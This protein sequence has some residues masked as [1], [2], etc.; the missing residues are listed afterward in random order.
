MKMKSKQFWRNK[1]K[2]I[3]SAFALIFTIVTM[4]GCTEPVPPGTIGKIITVNGITPEVYEPG[5]PTVWGRDR[6]ILIETASELRP[7]PVS[8]IMA[9]RRIDEQGNST[10]EAGLKM[11]FLVNIR[12]R[13]KTNPSDINAVLSDMSL[14]GVDRITAKQVYTKYGDMVIGRVSREVLGNYTPE[15]VLGNLEKINATLDKEVKESLK[16]SPLVI[17][18][19]SLGP[20]SLP[21]VIQERINKNKE[22]ELSEAE[23]RAQQKINLLEKQNEIELA[24][25]QAVRE[26]IDAQS[27][28]EQNRILNQSITPEVLELRRLQ[29]EEKRIEME[30]EVLS[31]GLSKGNGSVFIPYGAMDNVG[32]NNRMFQ[33]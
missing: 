26:K 21:N 20:I 33:K 23:R 1:M 3:L 13:I 28:A 8:V 24:R 27:L 5:R 15:E 4:T 17:S 6:L 30:R 29:L 16:D 19:V 9:D 10:H 2:K 7:A 22:V 12:Y 14:E 18:S 31:Q 25:Q 11:D 32:A